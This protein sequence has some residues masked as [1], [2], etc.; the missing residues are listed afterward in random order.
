MIADAA[1]EIAR[2][3]P[4]KSSRSAAKNSARA[5]FK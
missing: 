1:G 5:V 2:A 3:T 4:H